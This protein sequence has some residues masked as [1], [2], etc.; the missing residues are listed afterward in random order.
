M[1][2]EPSKGSDR[3]RDE[4]AVRYRERKS[5]PDPAPWSARR[6]PPT[7]AD[8]EIRSGNDAIRRRKEEDE[9]DLRTS[10]RRSSLRL[11]ARFGMSLGIT[12]L[13]ALAW[14]PILRRFVAPVTLWFFG[15]FMSATEISDLIAR[16][17][18]D[19]ATTTVYFVIAELIFLA[20]AV[21]V[22]MRR[23]GNVFADVTIALW[24]AY[25]ALSAAVSWREAGRF[26][27]PKALFG[28]DVAT[29]LFLV[30][31]FATLAYEAHFLWLW[32]DETLEAHYRHGV[33]WGA[34]T[35]IGIGF[36]ALAGVSLLAE[37]ALQSFILAIL[38]VFV[39]VGGA[40]AGRAVFRRN[41]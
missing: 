8:A 11:W 41:R 37:I 26:V 12:T 3:E 21:A 29:Y 10:V 2:T 17:T 38:L 13:F 30:P 39:V 33:F 36:F 31:I 15:L 23:R 28:L 7:P 1:A 4:V 27:P 9:A 24:S 34:S 22:V 35:V 14:G 18:Y 40:R 20:F 32:R 6:R 25:A 16:P 5:A 19:V